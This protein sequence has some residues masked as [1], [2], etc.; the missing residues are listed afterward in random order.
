MK[1]LREILAERVALAL[2]ETYPGVTPEVAPSADKRFGD[3]QSNVA[4]VLAKK[5]G[6]PPRVLAMEIVEKLEVSDLSEP[7]QVAGAGFIN[8]RIKP[9]F[10]GSRIAG[11]ARD[12]RLGV[13][14]TREKKRLVIDFG[15]PNVAK[16]LHVGH[17][18][19]LNLGSALSR[20]AKFLGHWVVRDNHIGD[21]GTQFGMLLVGWKTLLDSAALERDPLIEMERLYKTISNRCKTDEETRQAARAELVKL[22][23]GD[24][25]NLEIWHRMIDLSQKQFDTVFAR[26]G[27][28]YDVTLGESFYNPWLKGI[29][30]EL[31]E[32]G[33]A[34][35]SQGAK[36]VFSEG[37]LPDKE[38]PFRI[39]KEGK[40]IDMPAI[41]QK[42]DGA[43]NYTTTDLATLQY[44]I[45]TWSPD[46]IVYVTDGRQQLHFRQFFSIF[47]RWKP[48]VT[49]KVRFEHVWFGM[50]LGED[51]RP[52]R[53]RDG[54]TVR[55]VDLLN[56][57]EERAEIL[58]AEKN[59]DLADAERKEIARIVGLGA[60]KYADLLPARN[61]D[62][63]FSWE[64]MLSF[65]GNTA[66]YLQNAYV[67]VRS[68]F[69]KLD[70]EFIL[71]EMVTLAEPAELD[72]AKKLVQFAEVLPLAL[73]EYRPNV[74]ANYLYELA[75]VFH[76][77]FEACP[78]LKSAEPTRSSRL[79]LC[80]LTGATLRQGLM[81]LGIECPERM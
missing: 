78:V 77:F 51:N 79:A 31:M 53:T 73:D 48:E 20:I 41:I 12:E 67:R 17:I 46:A 59:P 10:L 18:R 50:I 43:A 57:A 29:V 5:A 54:D 25:E 37:I 36:C 35:E 14:E 49:E 80:Q 40:W 8:F 9:E 74:L 66:P 24:A 45:E 63:V 76:S 30:D 22:Q 28:E 7:P 61:T 60:V 16:P 47:R 32:K 15:S 11:M 68:I 33:I 19:S 70:T 55:L 58:V 38:D 81:L 34:R 26:L 71:P 64:R 65:Q 4:M 72:L 39:Q 42:V 62:Y 13:A 52:F 2:G 1:T 23:N 69:R 6:K 44:R 56:E 3:Y 75:G 27:V 21:W